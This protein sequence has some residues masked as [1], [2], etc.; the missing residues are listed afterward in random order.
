V[1]ITDVSPQKKKSQRFNIFVDGEF[2]F[3]ISAELVFERKVKVGAEISEKQMGDL[4]AA[5]QV[6]RLLNKVLNFLSF[7]P[8]SE[9]EVRNHLIR[10]GKLAEVKSDQEKIQHTQSV[11]KVINK[12][13]KLNQIN[14][15][16]FAIWWVRQRR[17]FR[18]VSD[19]FMKREL[20]AKGIDKEII[21]K[22]LTKDPEFQTEIALKAAQ[23]KIKSYR[24]LE[25]REV[26]TKLSQFL[27]RR[28]FE[29]ELVKKTVDTLVP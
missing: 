20:L 19:V 26:K 12:L 5:D 28:G 17:D 24:N 3:G 18:P 6:E 11:D 8:R 23:K 14:D 25:K 10:K 2:A 29:W 4:I 1:K 16:E 22:H 15:D 27:A 7:R 9:R 21:D 13:K